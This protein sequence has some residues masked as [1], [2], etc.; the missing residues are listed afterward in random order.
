MKRKLKFTTP[1]ERKKIEIFVEKQQTFHFI[2]RYDNVRRN[3]G[4]KKNDLPSLSL[5]QCNGIA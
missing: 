1:L 5:V 2:L 4:I 3:Q